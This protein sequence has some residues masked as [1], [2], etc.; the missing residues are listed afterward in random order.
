MQQKLEEELAL[1]GCQ[2]SPEE[3]EGA[4]LN[5]L[6]QVMRGVPNPEERLLYSPDQAKRFCDAV[7]AHPD[8]P[9]LPDEM[10]LRRL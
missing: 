5:I 1:Y 6:A 4:L 2:V 9:G 3:F 10:I 8:C 7:R